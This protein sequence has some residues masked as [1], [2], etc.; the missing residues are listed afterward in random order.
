MDLY[1]NTRGA[2]L[3]IKDEMFE[4]RIPIEKSN[5][6]RK[7]HFSALKIRS[8]IL[9]KSAALSTDAI[10]LALCH[11]IDILLMEYDGQP[12]GRI[13]H[14]RPSSTTKIRKRQLEASLNNE[15]LN[16][17]K[18]WIITK[19][20]NQIAL[21]KDLKKH[22]Q[23]AHEIIDSTIEIITNYIFKIS[24]LAGVNIKDIGDSIRGYEGS[25]GRAYFSLLSKLIPPKYRFDG[26]SMR[27]AKDAFNACLNYCYGILYSRTEK[28]LII[29]GLD[30]YTGFLHRDDYNQKSMVYDFIEQFRTYADEMVFKFFSTKAARDSYF[31]IEQG[32]VKLNNLGKPELVKLFNKFMEETKIR[33][34]GR[35]QNRY[36]IIQFEA[37]S[38][39][40]ELIQKNPLETPQTQI[41]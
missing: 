12:I 15:G 32:N 41:L 6:Y 35:N 34:K 29:A 40:N 11:H 13:W 22:R 10:F 37:H 27:P 21:L 26:R 18:K 39:A 38:F 17:I 5:E 19:L 33:Y 7:H 9:S 8:I 23:E 31:D 36:N 16:Y 24:Q 1:I 30:P 25:A 2:Y 20:E 3:H 28:A 14:C 4:V